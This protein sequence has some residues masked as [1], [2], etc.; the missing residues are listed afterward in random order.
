MAERYNVLAE[1][2]RYGVLHIDLHLNYIKVY[3]AFY[4]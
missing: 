1:F 4:C 2:E 3:S